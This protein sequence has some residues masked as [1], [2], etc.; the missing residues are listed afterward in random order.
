MYKV[1]N[2]Q[3]EKAGYTRR[4]PGVKDPTN[5]PHGEIKTP[6]KQ[7]IKRDSV[8]KERKKKTRKRRMRTV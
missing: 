4:L 5:D 1:H 3:L 7:I 6:A 2:S 8:K